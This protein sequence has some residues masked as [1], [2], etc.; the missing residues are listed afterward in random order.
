MRVHEPAMSCTD[1]GFLSR[2]ASSS[3][4]NIRVVTS[5]RSQNPDDLVPLN[6]HEVENLIQGRGIY[7]VGKQLVESCDRAPTFTM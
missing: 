4:S 2:L 5:R 1:V 6:L 3:N 7:E